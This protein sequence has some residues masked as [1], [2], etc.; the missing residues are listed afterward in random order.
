MAKGASGRYMTYSANNRF[1]SDWQFHC[2]PLTAG[3]AER[4]AAQRGR[5]HPR[6]SPTL[7]REVLAIEN[8]LED[9]YKDEEWYKNWW[10]Y[11]KLPQHVHV[12]DQLMNRHLMWEYL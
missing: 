3:Y 6:P 11:L 4:W 10:E 7:G 5:V 8:R 9:W 2:A 1:N 12:I